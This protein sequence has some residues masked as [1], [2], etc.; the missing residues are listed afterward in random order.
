MMNAWAGLAVLFAAHAALGA[1]CGPKARAWMPS[2]SEL[3]SMCP[4]E[5]SFKGQPALMVDHLQLGRVRDE[6]RLHREHGV[7]EDRLPRGRCSQPPGGDLGQQGFAAGE[8]QGDAHSG[9]VSATGA[10]WRVFRESG[11][12]PS[13]R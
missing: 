3:A 9:G 8:P 6:R 2:A 5:P 7:Q 11:A 10:I 13:R 12:I 1:D 4:G